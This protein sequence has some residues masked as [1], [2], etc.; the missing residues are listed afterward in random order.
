MPDTADHLPPVTRDWRQLLQLGWPILVTQLAIVGMGV[1]DTIMAGQVSAA[2]L[3]AVAIGF[4]IYVP[5]VMSF[6]GILYATTARIAYAFGAHNTV[7]LTRTMQQSAW[8]A[9][10]LTLIGI[11]LLLVSPLLMRLMAVDATVF[12][13]AQL[14]LYG[15]AFGLP[16]AML[17]QLLRSFS[18]GCGRSKP[19]M[20]IGI[21]GFLINIPLNYIYI[22]G[23]FGLPALGGAGCGFATGTVQW[24]NMI[25]LA[26]VLRHQLRP[27]LH[28]FAAP[29]LAEL[30]SLLALG[31]P[32]GGALFME[33]SIFAVVALLIG[34][35]GAET[36]AGHQ[37]AINLTSMTFMVPSSLAV[38]LTVKVGQAVGAGKL[39]RARR[40][41]LL[42]A[43][44]G[45]AFGA[46]TA[47]GMVTLA[48]PVV[49]LYNDDFDVRQLAAH[50]LLFAACY[51][52]TDALQV[53]AAGSL[54]GYHDT[55]VTL[56]ITFIAYWVVGLPLGYLL[57]LTDWLLPRMG[58]AGFWVGFIA[59]LSSAAVLLN[60]RLWRISRRHRS[61]PATGDLSTQ[62]G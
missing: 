9:L 45:I 19:V 24:L 31:L 17:F 30:K 10:G 44:T 8:L 29:H 40:F 42:G 16:G 14:Y 5:L 59:G 62:T 51:Q 57:G 43:V 37:I 11:V 39:R 7:A 22:H 47:L 46:L 61:L 55:R 2:D 32:I 18:E 58:V 23:L 13:I 49:A 60:I 33:V 35:L 52:I 25:A 12:P 20:A 26:V 1:A 50:L 28:R 6:C 34:H 21:G 41:A 48:E 56:V 4:S 3:A 36:L 53:T 15:V 38:A 27:L 54:R